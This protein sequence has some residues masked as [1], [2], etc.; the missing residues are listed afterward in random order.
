M[1]NIL[2]GCGAPYPP[3]SASGPKELLPRPC[4]VN[5]EQRREETEEPHRKALRVVR[6]EG[7]RGRSQKGTGIV[8]GGVNDK[9][10]RRNSLNRKEGWRS[11]DKETKGLRR[12]DRSSLGPGASSCRVSP[13][14]MANF[15]SIINRRNLSTLVHMAS[16]CLAEAF[17][18][19]CKQTHQQS[20]PLFHP[21]IHHSFGH[22]LAKVA[23]PRPSL[24]SGA[25]HFVPL[26]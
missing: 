18:F 25:I 1:G 2:R 7:T 10:S 5:E 26:H 17:S 19:P 9:A 3:F 6:E 13:V 23:S 11:E 14:D 8:W 4:R 16:I 21:H 12:E 15:P 22:P 20:P 24:V